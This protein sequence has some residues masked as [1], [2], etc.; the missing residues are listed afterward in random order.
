MSLSQEQI[1]SLF[2]LSR[3]YPTQHDI[4]KLVSKLDGMI[5]M[6]SSV[7]NTDCK[8]TDAMYSVSPLNEAIRQDIPQKTPTQ[9]VLFDNLIAKEKVFSKDNGYFRVK[10][11]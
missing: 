4:A 2:V 11:Q 9:D 7:E 3:I 5:E 8:N 1:K 6:V 10:Q